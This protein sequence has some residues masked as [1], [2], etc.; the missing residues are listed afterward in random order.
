MEEDSQKLKANMLQSAA[1]DTILQI[2]LRILSFVLNAFIVRQVSPEV[3]A[4]TTLHLHLLYATGL[5]LSR[6]AFRRAALSSKKYKEIHK[7]INLVWIGL[8]IAIPITLMCSYIWLNVMDQPN[9]NVTVH[10]RNG[11][12]AMVLCVIIE[13]ATE[14]PFVLAELQL[15]TKTKVII[16]GFMQVLRTVLFATFVYIWPLHA[17]LMYGI[18][19]ILGSMLYF[20][21]YY[22]VFAYTFYQ[23]DEVKKLPIHSLRQLF[24]KITDGR[25]YIEIDSEQKL[26]AWSFFKQGWLKEALTNGESYLMSFFSLISLAQQGTYQVVNNLGSLAARLV[27]RSIEAAAYKYF[28]QMM[29]R[30]KL[31]TDQDAEKVN[32]VAH[33]LSKLLRGLVVTSLVIVIFGFSYSSMLLRLYGGET[34]SH[35]IGTPLMRAQC[36]FVVFL[37][38]NGVTEAYTFAVMDDTQL[39]F[40]NRLLICFSVLYV[41]SAVLF[42]YYMGAIGFVIANCLNMSCRIVYSFWY[43][44]MHYK[45]WEIH[46]LASLQIPGNILRMFLFVGIMTQLSEHFIYTKSMILHVIVGGLCLIRVMYVLRWDLKVVYEKIL[47]FIGSFGNTWLI[48]LLMDFLYEGKDN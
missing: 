6:E 48:D 29:Y 1:Y 33:F 40:Y 44:H 28:A 15:W 38:I 34:L 39:G 47:H 31:L 41:V 10:Y 35:G 11:V 18:S 24:P 45:N 22:G 14:V 16:E 3:F 26:L 32:Q 25:Y 20:I 12:F 8:V 17:V 30:G 5:L 36:F 42:S 7:L 19:H 4:V 23:K 46:P 43:I 21:L 13:V 9:E 37:A 2:C 27:F